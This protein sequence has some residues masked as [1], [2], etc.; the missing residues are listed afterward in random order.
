MS[1]QKCTC[2]TVAEDLLGSTITGVRKNHTIPCKDFKGAVCCAG[3]GCSM[4]RR[5]VNHWFVVL[6]TKATAF[7]C[8]PYNRSSLGK[9]YRHHPGITIHPVCGFGC[10]Q[11]L[12]EQYMHGERGKTFSHAVAPFDRIL[13]GNKPL[14]MVVDE[15][16][17]ELSVLLEAAR[18]YVMS[19]E[20]RE[21]QR[22]SWVRGEMALGTDADEARAQGATLVVGDDLPSDP[23]VRAQA[24]ARQVTRP[25]E[26]M[27]AG[28][29]PGNGF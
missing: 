11:K 22:Q 2:P 27:G 20:E 23:G 9:L 28:Y 21:A 13:K 6:V 18:N 14:M 17:P 26:F 16:T 15:C 12:F 3:P 24:E 8:M 25:Q 5:A 10:A 29:D 19:P 1:K 4:E 7:V